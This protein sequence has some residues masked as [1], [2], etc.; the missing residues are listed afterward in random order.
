MLDTTRKSGDTRRHRTHAAARRPRAARAGLGARPPAC[1]RGGARR[2]MTS[3]SSSA[4]PAGAWCC[5]PPSSSSGCCRPGSRPWGGQTPGKRVIGLAV[6]NDDGTPVRWPGALT[7]NL[8]RAADFLP[9]PL[10]RRPGHHADEPR[11]QAPGRPRRRHGGGLPGGEG[12][13]RASIPAAPP[14]SRRRSPRLEE[15]RAARAR[16]ALGTLTRERFEELAEL[17]TPLV[18]RAAAAPRRAPARHREPLLAGQMKQA[19][20]EARHAAEWEDFERFLE[21][22]NKLLRCGR[23]MP[24]RFRRLCQSLA[25]AAERHYSADARRPAERLALRGHHALYGN[26]RRESQQVVEFMLAGFPALVRAEWRLVL[27]ATLLF[28]GPLLALIALLQAYP[29]F[30]HYLLAPGRSRASTRCTTRPT[31]GRHARGRHQHGDVRLLH[32]EQRAHRLPDL[33][34]RPARRRG[35]GLVPRRERR[36][37]RRGRGLSHA[38]RLQRDL[39]VVRRRPLVRSS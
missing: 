39:L 33:R 37:H 21:S 12:R 29:D 24:A 4:A 8:L 25:L 20:F 14:Q 10:R 2:S 15:Q 26:R 9:L 23:G 36:D 16:R 5:S 31:G 27:A 32:L 7:R 1:A 30:V 11:L 28:F 18:G 22:H 3:P 34:R 17:P 38:G 13:G 35:L 6:L 19:P